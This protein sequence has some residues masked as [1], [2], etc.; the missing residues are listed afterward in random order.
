M[1]QELIATFLATIT[2]LLPIVNPLYT[3]T[4][5]PSMV[6]N[7]SPEERERQLTRACYYAAGIL[8][9]FLL[10][11]A[12]IMDFFAISIPGLRI[13]GGLIVAYIGFTMLFPNESGTLPDAAQREA[14]SKRDI[15]FTPLAMPSIA[16]PG[17]I[18]VVVSLSS[19]M[20]NNTDLPLWLGY[21]VVI[22]GIVTVMWLS[23]LSLRAA[24][25][26][27]ALLGE[28]GINAVSRVMG[29]LLICIGVQFLINGVRD[30]LHDP[31]F[32]PQRPA[33]A[34]SAPAQP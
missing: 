13:A 30:L 22:V 5:L 33:A 6:V 21:L 20:H 3:A 23:W 15:S 14:E 4:V 11:G 8:I 32:I 16:G 7:L 18:A 9:T 12:L 29:F 17:S 25:R 19:S 27:Y 28:N 34:V 1:L 24:K 31:A 10:V 2:A 26:L